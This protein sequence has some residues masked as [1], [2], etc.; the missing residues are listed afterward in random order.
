M[1][2]RLTCAALL[3]LWQA[4]VWLE[5]DWIGLG[6]VGAAGANGIRTWTLRYVSIAKHRHLFLAS[7]HHR[8]PK[9]SLWQY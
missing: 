3:L 9:S 8:G 2:L 5:I 4:A 1:A 7:Y 6:L